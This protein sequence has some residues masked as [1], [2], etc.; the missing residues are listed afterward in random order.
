MNKTLIIIQREFLF[1]VKK[2]SFILLTV[3][4]PFIMVALVA[5]PLWLSSIKD[6]EQKM[7][8]VVDKTAHYVPCLKDTKSYHFFSAPAMLPEFRSDTTAVI[9]VIA[10]DGDLAQNP[11]DVTMYSR[12]E[13]SAELLSYVESCLNEQVR[14]DKLEASG[15]SDLDRIIADVQA[16]LSVSTVKWNDKGEETSSNTGIAI[17]AGFIFTFLIY[18]FVMSYGGMVMSSVTEE[19]TNRIMELMVSSVKPFQLMMG[20]IVGVALVG[21]VQLAIW[22]VMLAVLLAVVLPL[23]MPDSAALAADPAIMAQMNTPV[24]PAALANGGENEMLQAMQNLPYL[25][26]L[27][28]FVLMF[29]GGYLLYASFFAAVGASVNSPD[30]TSQFMMPMVF[31]MIFGLYAAMYSVENTNGP[32]AFWSSLFP[33]TSPIVMMVRIPFGVPL[34]QE[35]LSL[36]L[37]FGTALTFVWIGGKIYRVGILMYGKKPTLK[38]MLKWVRYK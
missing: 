1:R 5:I 17:A 9:A 37:L 27:T 11:K 10:I 3:L 14:K 26:L 25:E 36:V 30:D 19:K 35:V 21:F 13:I 32:L 7:V 23:F 28:M 20:K 8:A 34:W 31:I 2:K 33:L 15:I 12:E 4:M 38:E 29:I 24:D 18:M 6:S 16:S 22:G